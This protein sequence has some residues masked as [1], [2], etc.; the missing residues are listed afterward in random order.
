[1]FEAFSLEQ[2]HPSN[3]SLNLHLNLIYFPIEQEEASSDFDFMKNPEISFAV[4]VKKNRNCKT[5]SH[6]SSFRDVI[7][8]DFFVKF[9]EKK[10]NCQFDFFFI[11]T[12]NDG[13]RKNAGAIT[14]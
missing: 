11:L 9:L 12:R 13:E 5:T 2:I 6:Q 10:C 14:I 8:K 7:I 3:Y 4:D 1:M